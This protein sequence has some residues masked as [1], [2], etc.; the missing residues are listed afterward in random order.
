MEVKVTKKDVLWGYIAQI[1]N[2][3]TGFFTLP[4]ILNLLSPE[5]VGMNYIMLSVGALVTIADF[6]FSGQVGRNITYIIS[7]AKH[8]QKGELTESVSATDIHIDFHLLNTVIQAAKYLYQLLSLGI[9]VILLTGG[10]WYMHHV[11]DGFSNVKWSLYIWLLY[12]I[13][14]FFNF[15]FLYYNSLLS[16]AGLITEQKKAIIY[17]RIVYLILCIAM[18]LSGCGLLSVVSANFIA[19]FVVRF[20]SHIK[21]YSK[22]MRESL[23][24]QTT[25]LQEKKEAISKMW[26]TAKRSGT[27]SIGHYVGTQGTM[28]FAG[29]YLSLNEASQWGILQQLYGIV[30]GMALNMGL[31]LLPQLTKY[32]LQKQKDKFIKTLSVSYVFLLLIIIA[33]GICINLL[34]P[35]ALQL[36]KSKSH[37]PDISLMNFYFVSSVILVTAQLFACVLGCKN[38]IPSPK[39][40]L[41]TSAAA[42][43]LLFI[44]LHFGSLGLWALVLA[45]CLTGM[46]YTYWRWPQLVLRDCQLN[47]FQLIHI[48]IN[49]LYAKFIRCK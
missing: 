12:C 20:Y 39:A 24:G 29:I 43:V 35:F 49:E 26:Y 14:C 19:P 34:G 27:N 15:Y 33:G 31:S 10:T 47:I 41:T 4:V 6:G 2:V 36:I 25:T 17:S 44:L 9:L 38:I 30:Q 16:G 42:I 1:F 8:I 11:T 40:V 45:P 46:A 21:F 22:E 48:G 23:R 28:F 7:G 5:E 13:S 37:L 32:Q 3:G 18:L